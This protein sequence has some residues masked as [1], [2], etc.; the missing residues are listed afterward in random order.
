[1]ATTVILTVE[2]QKQIIKALQQSNNITTE[3][4]KIVIN[5]D[6]A[7][8]PQIETLQTTLNVSPTQKTTEVISPVQTNVKVLTSASAISL[9]VPIT[10]PRVDFDF[11]DTQLLV[12]KVPANS[13]VYMITVEIL[14]AFS[15]AVTI[16]VGTLTAQGLLMVALDNDPDKPHLYRADLNE[17]FA[18]L[19]EIYIFISGTSFVGQGNVLVHYNT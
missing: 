3:Q 19:S 13:I 15:G 7:T 8:Q 17:F 5:T 4:S 14:Q 1:M 12:G 11:N 10:M 18:T 9:F 2:Q 6:T 16:T